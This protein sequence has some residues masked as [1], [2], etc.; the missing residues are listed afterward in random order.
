MSYRFQIEIEREADGR[1]IAEIPNLPGVSVYGKTQQDAVRSVRA[2]GVITD[3]IERA[4]SS[5]TLWFSVPLHMRGER[6]AQLESKKSLSRV[7]SSWSAPK[8]GNRKGPSHTQLLHPN[9]SIGYTWVFTMTWRSAPT[10]SGVSPNSLASNLMISSETTCQRIDPASVST[11]TSCSRP[12]SRA[13]GV[14]MVLRPMKIFSLR[15]I[16]RR[17]SFSLTKT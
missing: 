8:P 2:L 14:R 16:A 7:V 3:R 13:E 5:P 9:K 1:W 10:H 15:V 4:K 12:R 11:N 6:L 17:T